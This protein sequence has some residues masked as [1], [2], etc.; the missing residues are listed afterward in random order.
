MTA[1]FPRR[2]L[3]GLCLLAGACSSRAHKEDRPLVARVSGVP[4][5]A[6]ELKREYR[7]IR[8]DDV[9]GIPAAGTEETQ[10]RALLDNLIER[11]LILQEAEHANVIVGT[12]EV[13][14]AVARARAGW[15]ESDFNA[16]LSEKD[17]TPSELKTELREQ[18]LIR[19]YFRDHVFSRIAVTDHEIE[20]YVE[21]HPE[22][23]TAPEQVHARYLVVRT[24]EEGDHVLAEIKAGLPI[25][26][27]AM[28]YSLAPDAKNGGD[29]GWF[30]RGVM[31]RVFDDVCF[32][33]PAGQTSK[34]VPG[35][36]GFYIFKV[37][38]KQPAQP[39]TLEGVREQ[40]ETLMRR[41]KERAAQESKIAE[42]RKA[43]VIDIQEEQ[44]A[45]IH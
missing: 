13:E 34:V 11:H 6:D 23:L 32:S 8:L 26:D 2:F 30:V 17:I 35:E 45:H 12:D 37:L 10:K 28:K 27:A 38:E 9:D 24:Q 22:K 31:P 20:A 25:E 5:Y 42:L 4:I 41:D 7:R 40:I 18:L 1:F 36:Y 43:A 16:Q 14:A 29:L 19:K 21:A 44:L 15:D 33:L 39:R 3:L